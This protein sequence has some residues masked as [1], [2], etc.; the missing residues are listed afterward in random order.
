M[1]VKDDNNV[2]K[3]Y[4]NVPPDGGWGYMIA[5]AVIILSSTSTAFV[6]SYGLLFKEFLRDIGG[7]SHDVSLIPSVAV[8][9]TALA[10][11]LTNPLLSLMSHRML[12]LVAVLIF[13]TGVVC[14]IFVK[15]VFTF[16]ICYG[17]LQG[18]GLGFMYN[19]SCSILNDYF[20][21]RPLMII[22][23]IQ[24]VVAISSMM[25]PLLIK[26][27][28][29]RYGFRDTMILLS[30][31]TLHNFIAVTL[32]HPAKW[33][34]KKVEIDS[35]NEKFLPEKQQ[36][37]DLSA[38]PIIKLT[39]ADGNILNVNDKLY[40]ADNDGTGINF[41]KIINLL[42]DK[43]LYEGFL[44][45][46]VCAGPALAL[47]ADT[48][49]SSILSQALK[50]AGWVKDNV[51]LANTLYNIGDLVMRLL[52]FVLSNWL[53]KFGS[54]ELY[55]LGVTLGL[56]SRLGMLW[57]KSYIAIM[58]Y[59]S[60]VGASHC[61]V[62]ILV[63]LVVGDAV[64]AKKFTSALGMLMMLTGIVNL[65]LGPAIGAV[66]DLSE[67]YGPVFYLIA[68]CFA[69]IVLFWSIEMCY[70]KNKHKRL[71]RREYLRQKKLNK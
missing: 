61:A 43:S 33:H 32:M 42:V 10:G 51:A 49:Y 41:R 29:D 37:E 39:N 8:T 54:Q 52:F 24:S 35:T 46:C 28:L 16:H 21:K 36:S 3:K 60:L 71:Q 4:K 69:I 14:I 40:L 48:T 26:W 34:M 12:T 58:I 66:R 67:S 9:C 57:S 22:S 25:A 44:L 5:F 19:L 65:V 45:S 13:N 6:S 64:P 17:I 11:F 20:V 63:P 27:S 18:L 1:N 70:K 50:T 68:S 55:V 59:I 62:T 23:L 31:L 30:G 15:S 56:V 38:I 47:F 7:S 2:N 53:H